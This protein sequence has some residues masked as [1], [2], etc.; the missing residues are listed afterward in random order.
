MSPL[1]RFLCFPGGAGEEG[2]GLPLLLG[3]VDQ[4]ELEAGMIPKKL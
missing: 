2:R 3:A 1:D 4:E